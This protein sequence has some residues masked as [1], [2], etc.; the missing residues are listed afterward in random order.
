MMRMKLSKTRKAIV[1]L[2]LLIIF[3]SLGFLVY[4][5]I[6]TRQ[7][8]RLV[9]RMNAI[10]FMDEKQVDSLVA[11]F[12]PKYHRVLYQSVKS[13]DPRERLRAAYILARQGKKEYIGY[14]EEGLKQDDEGEERMATRLLWSLWFNQ[15][16][17][18]SREILYNCRAL[19]S[20][21]KNDEAIVKLTKLTLRKPEFA[22]AYNQRALAYFYKGDMEHSISDCKI[23]LELNP[24]HFGAQS[25]MGECYLKL[26]KYDEAK[27]AFEKALK[28]TPHAPGTKALLE[29]VNTVLQR[30]NKRY[31]FLFLT[32]S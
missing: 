12:N 10:H 8:I 7:G 5:I 29:K 6:T 3:V 27:D 15:A 17:I 2:L 30:R 16:G 21:G 20:Q 28:I 26:R 31:A 13:P 24:I 22:E 32:L 19:M 23:A 1:G 9:A 11:D 25:G 4:N 18:D 14:L